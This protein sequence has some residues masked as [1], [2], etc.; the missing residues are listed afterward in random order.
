MNYS[1]AILG[2]LT[3]LIFL[4]WLWKGKKGYERVTIDVKAIDRVQSNFIKVQQC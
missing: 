2:G 4:W 1:S 3:I